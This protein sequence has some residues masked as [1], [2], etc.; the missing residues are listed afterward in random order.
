[1]ERG[2]LGSPPAGVVVDITPKTFFWH[3][4]VV[5]NLVA[6]RYNSVEFLIENIR[7]A[8]GTGCHKSCRLK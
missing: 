6:L 8:L 1:M 3:S 5:L 2:C 7:S 4:A